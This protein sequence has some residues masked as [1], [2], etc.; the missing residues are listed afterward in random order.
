MQ[1][2]EQFRDALVGK[3]IEHP[4]PFPA[5]KDE[6]VQP[7]PR[8]LLRQRRL[9]KLKLVEKLV[10]GMLPVPEG[11][12]HRQAGRMAHRFEE[13]LRFRRMSGKIQR[14]HIVIFV[15]MNNNVKDVICEA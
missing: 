3:R 13:S 1:C 14:I 12:E 11:A 7:Q 8:K 2:G 4:L 5:R 15:S 10:D 6:P 9:A